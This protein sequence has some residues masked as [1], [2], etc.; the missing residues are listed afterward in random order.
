MLN[1]IK[2]PKDCFA[3]ARIISDITRYVTSWCIIL[4]FFKKFCII[5]SCTKNTWVIF[6]NV[7]VKMWSHYLRQKFTIWK[8]MHDRCSITLISNTLQIHSI[9]IKSLKKLRKWKTLLESWCFTLIFSWNFKVAPSF[10]LKSIFAE[11]SFA[12]YL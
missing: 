6:V 1:I 7:Y 4:W 12:K 8:N 9:E 3:K 5:S 2:T 10:S 11:Q